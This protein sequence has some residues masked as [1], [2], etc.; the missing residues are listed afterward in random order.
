MKN[1]YT[2]S[3]DWRKLS[4]ALA[5][6]VCALSAVAL[7]AIALFIGLQH[8]NSAVGFLIVWAIAGFSS[9]IP[10]NTCIACV[11]KLRDLNADRFHG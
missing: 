6:P 4:C 5:I 8:I 2:V 10:T 7:P 3:I 11:H 9:A 1:R